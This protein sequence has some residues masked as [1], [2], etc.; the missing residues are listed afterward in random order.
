MSLAV[1]VDFKA[2][3][4]VF[5][6]SLIAAVGV[7][8]IFSFGIVG[9]T[10]YDERRRGGGGGKILYAALAALCALLVVAAVIQGIIVM[11]SK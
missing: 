3:G 5:L 2:L 7:T 8:T 1:V 10:R 6:V 9:I 4:E 11:T